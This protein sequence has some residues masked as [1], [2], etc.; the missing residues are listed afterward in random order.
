MKGKVLPKGDTDV[1]RALALLISSTK[2]KRR[3]ASLVEIAAAVDVAKGRFGSTTKVAEAIGLSGKMLAQFCRV[4]GLEPEVQ[5]LVSKKAIDSVDAVAHL[6]QLARREQLRAAT[7]LAK[8]EIDTI[9]LRA[10]VEL[11]K[12][13]PKALFE[14]IIE[15]VKCSKTQREYVAE[16]IVRSRLNRDELLERFKQL[17]SPQNI[18]GLALSGSFGRIRFNK[19]GYREL[20]AAARRRGLNVRQMATLATTRDGL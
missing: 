20:T 7:E 19:Q 13:D 9:D 14:N 15:R 1:E 17:V 8:R 6:A 11:R 10:L 3:T 12:R 16:F 4:N 5:E 2:R 18:L